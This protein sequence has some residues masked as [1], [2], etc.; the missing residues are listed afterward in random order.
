[1]KQCTEEYKE[2]REDFE[3]GMEDKDQ[4]DEILFYKSRQTRNISRAKENGLI[5]EV[6]QKKGGKGG[7]DY[8]EKTKKKNDKDKDKDCLL[9]TSRCV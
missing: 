9:Y 5:N 7:E 3:I 8:E 1:M 6:L 2:K 4:P